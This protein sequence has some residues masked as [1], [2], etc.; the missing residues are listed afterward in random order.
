MNLLRGG[1]VVMT[2]KHSYRDNVCAVCWQGH[3]MHG[4]KWSLIA[5]HVGTRKEQQCR[6]RWVHCMASG[7][8]RW[9]LAPLCL[10]CRAQCLR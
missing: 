1:E 8:N 6:E 2:C 9:G 7:I 5:K 10:D 3:Q 4:D